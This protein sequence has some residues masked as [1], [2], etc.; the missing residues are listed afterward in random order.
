MLVRIV[1]SSTDQ[2]L[3]P[4]SN[5][6]NRW[7]NPFGEFIPSVGDVTKGD[8]LWFWVLSFLSGNT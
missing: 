8:F 7:A 4:H 5:G 6:Y 1:E 2:L 3:N